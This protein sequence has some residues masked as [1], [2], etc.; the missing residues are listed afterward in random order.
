MQLTAQ[1]LKIKL[2]MQLNKLNPLTIRPNN[3][4]LL[5]IRQTRQTARTILLT[6]PI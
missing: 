6:R 1:P 3:Q 2:V 4:L 5:A